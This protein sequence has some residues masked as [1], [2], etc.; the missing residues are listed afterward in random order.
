MWAFTWNPMKSKGGNFFK[1]LRYHTT[2]T[3]KCEILKSSIFLRLVQVFRIG[4]AISE[5]SSKKHAD[6]W[7]Q[8][9]ISWFLRDIVTFDV[10]WMDFDHRNRLRHEILYILMHLSIFSCIFMVFQHFYHN[11]SLWNITEHYAPWLIMIHHDGPCLTMVNHGSSWS[12][13]MD[14]DRSWSIMIDHDPSWW[15]MIAHDPWWSIK[16]IHLFFGGWCR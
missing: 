10:F 6:S 11:P 13:T 16:G 1:S 7:G 9:E 15:I 14:H 8:I 12:I 3:K 5:I 2:S 4:T